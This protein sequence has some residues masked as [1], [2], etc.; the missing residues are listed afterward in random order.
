MAVG[1]SRVDFVRL[2]VGDA[3]VRAELVGVGFRLPTS[4]EVPLVYATRLIREGTPSVT[5]DLRRVVPAPD[6]A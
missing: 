5:H 2:V 3:G 6:A 1:M 4:R